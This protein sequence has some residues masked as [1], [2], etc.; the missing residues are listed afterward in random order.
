MKTTTVNTHEAKT[1]LSRLL[2]LVEHGEEVVIAR[3]GKPIAKL[4]RA[5]EPAKAKRELGFLR[6]TVVL[7]PEFFEPLSAD[8][9]DWFGEREDAR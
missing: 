1:Q 3:N 9:V 5:Q 6:G 2:A 4:V 8:D 7:G